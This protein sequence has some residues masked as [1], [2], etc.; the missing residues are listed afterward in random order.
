M[1]TRAVFRATKDLPELDVRRHD[2]VVYCYRRDQP[3]LVLVR[4]DGDSYVAVCCLSPSSFSDL[5]MNDGVFVL[6]ASTPPSTTFLHQ[7]AGHVAQQS[8]PG[9]HLRLMA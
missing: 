6:E 1:D 2:C 8:K 3:R 9:A 7:L 5:L 4:C